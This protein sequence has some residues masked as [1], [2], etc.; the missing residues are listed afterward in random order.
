MTEEYQ[1]FQRIV[2]GGKIPLYK[3]KY[4][5]AGLSICEWKTRMS[6]CDVVGPV[7]SP[8]IESFIK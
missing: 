3:K 7:L 2:L 1:I 4:T 5:C 8:N 6:C